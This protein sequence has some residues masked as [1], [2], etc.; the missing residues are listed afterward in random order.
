MLQSIRNLIHFMILFCWIVTAVAA[1]LQEWQ[2]LD[3][4]QD[5]YQLRESEIM[6]NINLKEVSDSVVSALNNY[7]PEFSTGRVDGVDY[8][9]AYHIMDQLKKEAIYTNYD[10]Y[11]MG[12]NVGFCFGRAMYMHLQL[13]RYGVNKDSIKKVFVVGPM[14]VPGVMWQ[15]HVATVVKS[16]DSDHW[17]ALDTNLGKPVLLEEWVR[18][19]EKR[20]TDRSYD[21]FFSRFLD[22]PVIDKTK[23]LRFYI[24]EPSKIG[25][26]GWEYNIKPGGL[27]DL[28][29]NDYFKDMFKSFKQAKVLQSEK[30]NRNQC[31]QLFR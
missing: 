28:F 31:L 30:F 3:L 15:F 6:N 21:G 2:K 18:H 17:W 20:S 11:D 12:R 26:S 13:L 10:Q 9:Q 4:R 27:F 19:Y 24:T 14:Q 7:K 29:Y 1:D 8:R 22:R 16:K 23:S 5:L 25:P